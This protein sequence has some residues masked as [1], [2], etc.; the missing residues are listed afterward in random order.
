MSKISK[1]KDT[2][3]SYAHGAIVRM[4]LDNFLTYDSLEFSPGPNLNVIIGPNGTG[5]STIVCAICLGMTGKPSV[6]GRAQN[7]SDFIKH[8][9]PKGSIE[10]ELNNHHGQNYVIKRKL[11]KDNKSEW[12]L[13]E[14]MV[15][16]KE[17]EDLVAEL[18]IQVDNLCQFLPQEKVAEFARMNNFQLLES[19]EK[20]VSLVKTQF[21][22]EFSLISL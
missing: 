21:Q 11:M 15:K 19:T 10:I 9:K 18:N 8:G 16:A 12:Y 5:K 4:K 20:A 1:E 2:K 3:K 22:Y 7:I 17:I 13:N 6:L 14:K